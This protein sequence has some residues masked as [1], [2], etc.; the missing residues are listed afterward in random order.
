MPYD[1]DDWF[2]Q[3]GGW[4]REYLDDASTDETIWKET[5]RERKRVGRVD[6]QPVGADEWTIRM[7]KLF[8]ES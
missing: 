7:H 2:M 5:P 8:E 6:T 1:S 3:E 4:T